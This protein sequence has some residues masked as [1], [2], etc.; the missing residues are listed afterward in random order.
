[1]PS[2]ANP[3]EDRPGPED[4]STTQLST[5][6]K[7]V[8]CIYQTTPLLLM[9]AMTSAA[10]QLALAPSYGGTLPSINHGKMITMTFISGFVWRVLDFRMDAS[11]NL[12]FA[13]R[14]SG[15]MLLLP[16]WA[17]WVPFIQHLLLQFSGRLGP[18]LGL[19]VNSFFNCH[20]ILVC[21]AYAI[22]CVLPAP[23]LRS[24]H[25]LIA[26]PNTIPVAILTLL[27]RIFE[28]SALYALKELL[29]RFPRLTPIN[30]QFMVTVGYA[31]KFPS[32]LLVL[33]I[34]AFLVINPHLSPRAVD[35]SLRPYSWT[36][37]ERQWSNTGYISVL[38]SFDTE[39]RVMRCDHSLLGGEWLL[40]ENRKKKEGWQTNEPIYAVFQMLE[41]VRLM[42]L[43]P[44][45]PDS[46]AQALV[47][48][49]GIGT[50]PKA[51]VGHGIQ[52]TVV[53]LDPVVH[54]FATRYFDLPANHTAVIQ[55][56]VSWAENAAA[57]P[58]Q[59]KYDYIIHDVFTGGTE[60]L[61]LFTTT[62]LQNL[63]SLLTP[64]GVIAINYAGDPSVALTKRV[65]NS[66]RQVFSH[67]CKI[68]RDGPPE[69]HSPSEASKED[70]SDFTNLVVFCRNTPGPITFRKPR[71]EDFLGSKS[72]QYYMLPKPEHEIPFPGVSQKQTADSR[73]DASSYNAQQNDDQSHGSSGDLEVLTLGDLRDRKIAVEQGKSAVRHWRIMRKVLP[74]VVWDLW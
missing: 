2:N 73:S 68:Y 28:S 15:L 8:I 38:E 71:Q 51:F 5:F 14:I 65:F 70:D 48:G 50:A 10:S 31:L 30:F 44:A 66:I 24:G 23:A 22:A 41:A 58:E 29:P 6:E 64:N 1:M 26:P 36:L 67:Q 32:K 16:V 19:A 46:E 60:P 53:E 7:V 33:A 21:T 43:E 11:G 57:L 4:D 37:L 9:A 45:I 25:S 59:T 13:T 34:P 40:T 27:F 49:L 63:R 20:S 61:A 72:R 69:K 42:Q 39:Y 35:A 54:D 17:A 18:I 55:D 47:I 3:Q 74:D 56:A 52:T 12:A 62:F